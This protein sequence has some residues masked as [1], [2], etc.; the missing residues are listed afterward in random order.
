LAPMV[1][2]GRSAK[3]GL[4]ACKTETSAHQKIAPNTL[5]AEHFEDGGL[6]LGR[7]GYPAVAATQR[8]RQ[9]ALEGFFRVL[10]QP[11]ARGNPLVEARLAV[12]GGGVNQA[13]LLRAQVRAEDCHRAFGKRPYRYRLAHVRMR[14]GQKRLACGHAPRAG[15]AERHAVH[16]APRRHSSLAHARAPRPLPTVLSGLRV[17]H[18]DLLHRND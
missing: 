11:F 14:R 18:K 17:F 15:Q 7:E 8:G 10:L 12:D 1:T 6:F 16:D 2:D 13:V 9:S 3:H 4:R 5:G